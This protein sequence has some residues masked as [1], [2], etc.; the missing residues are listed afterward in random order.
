MSRL[1]VCVALILCFTPTHAA[2]Q[3]GAATNLSA[4]PARS[5]TFSW[6]A[7]DAATY[8]YLWITDVSGVPRH[9][10]WYRSDDLTCGA[11]QTATCQISLATYLLPGNGTWWVQ[12]WNPA[13]YGPWTPAQTFAVSG[14]LFAVVASNGTLARGNAVSSSRIG[15]GQF[16]VIF[17]RDVSDCAFQANI[18]DPGTTSYGGWTVGSASRLFGQPKGVAVTIRLTSNLGLSDA[19]FHLTV[20]CP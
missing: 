17:A 12:T 3:P 16:E 15:S 8:Y 20:T 19:P 18:G 7:V 10:Q 2:A 14:P 5:L 13:G 9:Q 4:N 11:G 6:P 1:V